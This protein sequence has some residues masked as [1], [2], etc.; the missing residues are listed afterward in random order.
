[1]MEGDTGDGE[2]IATAKMILEVLAACQFLLY[3]NNEK[4]SGPEAVSLARSPQG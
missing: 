2:N 4:P 3:L 1:M